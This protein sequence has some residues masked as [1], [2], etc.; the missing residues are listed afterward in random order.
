MVFLCMQQFKCK[1]RNTLYEI[2]QPIVMGILNISPD[3]FYDGSSDKSID[4]LVSRTKTMIDDGAFIID[5]GPSTSKPG[6]ELIPE[7][8]EF[9]RVKKT[10][11][12]LRKEFPNLLF[13]MDTRRSSIADYALTEGIDIINDITAGSFDPL[14]FS[15]CAKHRVP[16]IIMDMPDSSWKASEQKEKNLER[17]VLHLKQKL[18]QAREAGIN[19]VWI[20]P[21]FGFGKSVDEN[22]QILAN[23]SVFQL[24]EVPILVGVSR[25]S[26]IYKYLE[27]TP[28]NALN[29]T[30]ALHMHA[31]SKGANILRTHDVEEA[32]DCIAL[33]LKIKENT[34]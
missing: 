9:F 7:E 28:Q 6:S 29:G 12:I 27:T 26:M 11:P 1:V 4:E 10:I 2:N 14:M 20:D 34:L 18:Q 19:D 30:T 16:L 22:Y 3:S 15:V 17:V 5:I 32:S 13:S 21:G 23:L 25:K 31:L 8:E 24:L 33:H